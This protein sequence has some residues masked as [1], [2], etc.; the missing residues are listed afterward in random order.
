MSSSGFRQHLKTNGNL[1]AE[2]VRPL[3]SAAPGAA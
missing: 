1:A 3:T 2:Y